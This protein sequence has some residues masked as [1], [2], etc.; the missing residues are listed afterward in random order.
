[1]REIREGKLENPG[2]FV[3]SGTN[4]SLKVHSDFQQ[5]VLVLYMN[6]NK[7]IDIKIDEEK[8]KP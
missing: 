2:I 3:G 7:S 6:L 1:M 8:I 5:K 4:L